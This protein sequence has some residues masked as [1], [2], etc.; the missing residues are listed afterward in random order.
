MTRQR[1]TEASE[2]EAHPQRG[3]QLTGWKAIA[4]YL[5]VSVRCAQA[6]EAEQDMPVHRIGDGR[7]SRVFAFS[8][9]LDAWRR[10]YQAQWAGNPRPP[11]RWLSL[12]TG[13]VLAAFLFFLGAWLSRRFLAVESA[14]LP[15]PAA[16]VFESGQI[17]VLDTSGASAFTIPVDD[18]APQVYSPRF[19]RTLGTDGLLSNASVLADLDGDSRSE[20]LVRV[21]STGRG[22]ELRCYEPDGRLRW[23]FRVHRRVRYGRREFMQQASLAFFGGS[24]RGEDGRRYVLAAFHDRE[25]F[26]F[27]VFLLDA[28]T[29]EPRGEYWHP[30]W[31]QLDACVFDDWDG[32]GFGELLL[33]GVNNPGL[34]P[35]RPAV[36]VLDV[37][38]P[39]GDPKRP[40]LFGLPGGQEK[41]YVLFGRIDVWETAR[42]VSHVFRLGASQESSYLLDLA[43]LN[44]D[45]RVRL[46]TDRRFQVLEAVPGDSTVLLHRDFQLQGILDHD[47][48]TQELIEALQPLY[49]TTAPNANDPSALDQGRQAWTDLPGKLS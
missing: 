31:F 21:A 5:D 6:W 48:T 49:F 29:G 44:T 4:E 3:I 23:S 1:E 8:R 47:L 39:A 40:N 10:R 9:E 15:V 38:F 30:G 45:A 34:G 32:D 14:D 37:P 42:A 28:Q 19:S 7:R 25:F 41:F 18:L 2:L 35:G 20:I 17:K 12:R 11:A 24:V 13:V 43:M 36:A 27:G 16:V 33:G 26:P 22:D 46:V